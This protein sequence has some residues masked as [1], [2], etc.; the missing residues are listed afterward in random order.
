VGS[1]G[2]ALP[3]AGAGGPAASDVPG[4]DTTIHADAIGLGPDLAPASALTL[5][6]LALLSIAATIVRRQVQQRRLRAVLLA[7]LAGLRAGDVELTA[8]IGGSPV[9]AEPA[10]GAEGVA[11]DQEAITGPDPEPDPEPDHGLDPEPEPVPQYPRARRS[12]DQ[13]GVP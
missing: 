13:T 1:L 4:G 10:V 7:R 6:G 3:I 12:T 9:A 5:V 2:Q 11:V 8:S